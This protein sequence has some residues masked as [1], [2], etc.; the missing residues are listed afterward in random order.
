MTTLTSTIRELDTLRRKHGA[1]SDI[2]FAASN[3]SEIVQAAE[4]AETAPN[5]PANSTICQRTN[6]MKRLLP[7]AAADL[8]RVMKGEG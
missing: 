5:A 1:N 7:S 8:A 6:L 4:T 3:L 2:G